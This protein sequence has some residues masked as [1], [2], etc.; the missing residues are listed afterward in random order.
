MDFLEKQPDV[1][2]TI[3]AY[4]HFKT[5]CG[6]VRKELDVPADSLAAIVFVK[7]WL[8]ATYGINPND[9]LLLHKQSCLAESTQRQKL[10]ERGDTFLLLPLISGG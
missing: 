7:T 10:V 5:V 9:V 4:G 6:F 3:E 8:S 2:V 1:S